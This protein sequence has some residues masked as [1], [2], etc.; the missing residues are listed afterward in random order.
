MK[1]N[2]NHTHFIL[3]KLPEQGMQRKNLE[4]HKKKKI[5]PQSTKK[6]RKKS[7]DNIVNSSHEI[8]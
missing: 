8:A 5:G 1:V 3:T 7:N 2:R 6:K 4:F